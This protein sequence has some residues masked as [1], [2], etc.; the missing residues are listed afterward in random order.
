[1]RILSAFAALSFLAGSAFAGGTTVDFETET[2]GWVGPQGGG[3]ST[4]LDPTGGNGGG[5]GLHTIFNNFGV[6]FRTSTNSTFLGDYTQHSEVT[7]SVDLEV[8]Q[9]DFGFPVSRPWLLELRDFDTAQGGY[10]YTSV[11]YLFDNIS[12]AGNPGWTTYS[13]TIDDPSS[14]TLPAGWEGYGDEDALANPILPD[15]VTFADVL[16]GVD[17]VAL[18]TLQ[19]GFFFGFTD[20]DL[21]I[22]N[23]SIA[24]PDAD[25]WSDLGGGTVGANGPDTLAGNGT[26]VGGTTAGLDSTGAP[27]NALTLAW[28]SFS[29]VPFNA[30]GGTV[31]AAP[32]SNQ[33]LF[34][35]D[36]AGDVSVSTT[37]PVGVPSGTEVWFQFLSAD[38][39]V[40]W[41]ITMTNGLKATTP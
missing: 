35:A 32:F 39:S 12:V 14:T 28:L 11:W 2:Q 20:F 24:F 31:H 16:S 17:E 27:A 40:V 19:P 9:V 10:P 4:F 34:T 8:N 37:W 3:G 38:P 1:M 22:D 15:G 21:V 33:F 25:P 6:T 36:G 7:L 18:H 26:L 29:S 5:G 41:G 23:V 30:L 13:V